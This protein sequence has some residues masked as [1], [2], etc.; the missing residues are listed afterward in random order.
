MEN[1]KKQNLL[2]FGCDAVDFVNL[3]D[4]DQLYLGRV[5]AVAFQDGTVKIGSSIRLKSRIANFNIYVGKYGMNA[6][7]RVIY[8]SPHIEFFQNERKLQ[9]LFESKK[10]QNRGWELFDI[11]LNDVAG[12]TLQGSED[13]T[14]LEQQMEKL[15]AACKSLKEYKLISELEEK[16]L[17]AFLCP[18]EAI[19]DYREQIEIYQRQIAALKQCIEVVK[20]FTTYDPSLI[21][22]ACDKTVIRNIVLETI[23]NVN[24]DL[25]T[26]D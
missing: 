5:Y 14:L 26:C 8:T 1:T 3:P 24:G 2:W 10:I 18:E 19:L 16:L 12:V 22:Y 15:T 25:P 20:V 4:K 17:K 13:S 7:V 9:S 21:A 6:P 11:P 23:N